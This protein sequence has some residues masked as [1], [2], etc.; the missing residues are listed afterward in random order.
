[1]MGAAIGN[2]NARK[3]KWAEAL[4]K[5]V[6]MED[7]PEKRRRL[8]SIAL[9]LIEK[10]E[11]GDI[12]AIKELGDRIDGKPTQALEHS[13]PDGEPIKNALSVTFVTP[14]NAGE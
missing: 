12:Q 14:E 3:G 2:Q 7:G 6:L 1:M 10:A 8:D 13:G 5:A 11:A 9:R 4:T